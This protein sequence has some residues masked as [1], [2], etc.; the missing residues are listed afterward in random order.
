MTAAKNGEI[1]TVKDLLSTAT[2]DVNHTGMVSKRRH[3]ALNHIAVVAVVKT[4]LCVRKVL[5]L[6]YFS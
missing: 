6:L 1:E 4:L 2:V 5:Y 3:A